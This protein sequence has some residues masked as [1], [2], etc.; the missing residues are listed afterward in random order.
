MTMELGQDLNLAGQVGPLPSLRAKK[1]SS[2]GK[3]YKPV[4]MTLEL[5]QNGTWPKLRQV[6]KPC[7]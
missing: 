5:G 6:C 7:L 4:S 1:E 2:N 3:G